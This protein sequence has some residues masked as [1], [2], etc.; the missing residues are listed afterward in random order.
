MRRRW[1]STVFPYTTLFRSIAAA[2]EAEVVG[3]TRI[4]VTVVIALRQSPG[5]REVRHV[6]CRAAARFQD[7]TQVVILHQ[8]DDEIIEV[9]PRDGRDSREGL[10]RGR[11]RR[12]GGSLEGG[13]RQQHGQAERQQRRGRVTSEY[14]PGHP[15]G[16]K[17]SIP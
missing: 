16:R 10:Q 6:S 2:G 13:G 1:R 8:D 9:R 17:R 14:L 3:E 5:A 11:S 4:D 12:V 7:V 15:R